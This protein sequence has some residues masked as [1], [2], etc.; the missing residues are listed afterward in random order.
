MKLDRLILQNFRSHQHLDLTFEPNVTV[1]V[2]DNGEGKTSVLD[3]ISQVFGRFLS[4]LPGIKGIALS[5][6]DLRIVS[7]NRSAPGFRAWL[8]LDIKT[9]AK[10]LRGVDD[11]ITPTLYASR[12]RL[13]DGSAKTRSLFHKEAPIPIP[14]R[15]AFKEIDRFADAIVAAELDEL[16]YR[17]PLIAYYGTDR[18]V[19]ETPLRRRNFRTQF[20]RFDCFDGSLNANA[21]FKR[22]FEWFHAKETEEV[23]TQR[24]MQSFAYRDPELNA[25]RHAIES[26]FEDFT[27]PRTTVRPLRF[28]VDKKESSKKTI[29]FDLNQLS[30]GY[31]TTLAMVA[32]LACRMVEA[33][34]PNVM[35]NP[36]E[37]E[38]IVLIDE[39]DLHLH[40]RWQQRIVPDLLRVFPNTQFIVTTHSPQV[41]T[42]VEARSIRK[43]VPAE[44]VTE[45]QVPNFS[46]GAKSVQLLED[47]QDVDARPQIPIIESFRRYRSL[48]ENDKWDSPEALEIRAELDAWAA[49]KEPELKRIDIDIKMREFRR[50]KK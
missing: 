17:M 50:G 22:V 14:G 24:E 1:L 34:P 42:T 26:F 13:R 43:L 47:I 11:K 37:A 46:L 30:D 48:V 4:K 41:L 6:A 36:L 5:E 44:N 21:N 25:V 28:V 31:R 35:K 40:P 7:N 15:G 10:Y 29:T 45:V 27:N 20:A 3:A 19:F 2:G 8:E 9:E 49:N 23:L 32:D 16:Q 12:S 38:A 39:V 18:A 33:N